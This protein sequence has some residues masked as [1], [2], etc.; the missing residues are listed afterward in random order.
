MV[1][2]QYVLM[3][4]NNATIIHKLEKYYWHCICSSLSP[5]CCAVISVGLSSASSCTKLDFFQ[6]PHT[7]LLLFEFQHPFQTSLSNHW[8]RQISWTQITGCRAIQYRNNSY[9]YWLAMVFT[10]GILLL[11][12][13]LS[14]CVWTEVWGGV[15]TKCMCDFDRHP[16]LNNWQITSRKCSAELSPHLQ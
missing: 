8:L 16:H 12:Q 5:P 15:L 9:E 14:P 3:K 1:S 4:L 11:L 7:T 6:F 10:T 13:S 2:L